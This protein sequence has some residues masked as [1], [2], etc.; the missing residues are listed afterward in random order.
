MSSISKIHAR[1]VLDSRG[2]PTVEVEV[3]C[4][5]KAFGRAIVPS[6][7]STGAAEALELRDT[8]VAWFDGQGVGQ[9]VDNVNKTL[10]PALVGQD[11]TDQQAIDTELLRLDSSPQ[12]SQ[13]GGN[14][15]LGVSLAVAH[16]AAA[17]Q[18]IPLYRHINNLL[19]SSASN[20]PPTLPLPMTNMIS[21]GLHAGGNLDF[22]DVLIA[23]RGAPDYRTG[24]EW[25]VRVYRR[26][27]D[28]LTKSGFEGRLVGDE[29]GYGPRLESN[30]Q[31][32]AFVVQAI[33]A[34]RL[35]PGDDVTIALDV[36]ATHFL[37]NDGT[38]RLVTER[39]TTLTGAEMIDRLEA[40][41]DEFPITSIED[42]LAEEDWD[43]WRTLTQ[44]L[45]D[46][47]QLVGDD[48]FTTNERRIAKGIELGV[49]NSVLIKV[50][51]IGTLT[52]ALR[53]IEV[54]RE[55]G[56]S[57]VVSARSG[58]TEDTTIADLAVGVAAEQIKI[59]SIVRSER[60]AKYNQL[61]RI[62]EVLG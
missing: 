62:A 38:Y 11:A 24:L 37:Q 53:A 44:R 58:E 40:W 19:P 56:Y 35:R 45:G 57:L 50:N 17:S 25:I 42:G 34:A 41:V 22:Q 3:T 55:A 16:A 54:A 49:G 33:E 10:A 28:L 51:Q 23:P 47:I 60:L 8:Q 36:A 7:A 31:A 6:G 12:K 1:E 4:A 39:D 5:N 2:K 20:L 26:L 15:L 18:Q 46:R 61:L 52:E 30:R 21:G 59:G 43:G 32:V 13:L 9:A 14:A 29:G 48:L 27:G